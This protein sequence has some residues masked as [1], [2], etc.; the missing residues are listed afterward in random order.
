MWNRGFR[1]LESM[2]IQRWCKRLHL[3]ALVKMCQIGLFV[4][5]LKF[6]DYE[7]N[8]HITHFQSCQAQLEGSKGCRLQCRYVIYVYIT[9]CTFELLRVYIYVRF[10]SYL[11]LT[12]LID[13]NL[14]QTL[15]IHQEQTRY[16]HWVGVEQ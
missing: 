6:E 10:T 3:F 11:Y 1:K 8:K 16:P 5:R 14:R 7:A 13:Y 15:M 2:L 12:P 4:S 9:V